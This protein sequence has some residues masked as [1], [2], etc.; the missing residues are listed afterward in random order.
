M[1]GPN[2][3]FVNALGNTLDVDN[4]QLITTSGSPGQTPWTAGAYSATGYPAVSV[5]TLNSGVGTGHMMIG[6]N[7]AAGVPLINDFVTKPPFIGT[8]S[9]YSLYFD[10]DGSL[11]LALINGIEVARQ[12]ML[13]PSTGDS[14]QIN[15]DGISVTFKV[16]G[17]LLY[18]FPL[19]VTSFYLPLHVTWTS[20]YS[21]AISVLTIFPISVSLAIPSNV[22][23]Y[24]N[25]IT[26][27]H[28]QKPN[29]MSVVGVIAGAGADIV[30][31]TQTIQPAFNLETAV[32][33]QL[34]ILGLWI[35]QS[36]R[37]ANVLI[38]GF[39][40]FSEVSTGLPDG[41]QET[42]G[43]LTNSSK[44]GVWFNL[45]Q[46]DSGTTILNDV[47][48]LTILKAK[49]VKNQWNGTISG[50]E[51]ALQYIV[52]AACSIADT[53]NLTLTI[54]VPV[55]ITPLEEA[56]LESLDLIPRPAGVRID[57]ITFAP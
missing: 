13:G 41:L 15:Y 55:P 38:I 17:L 6:L 12:P 28:N 39:F 53:G 27:E 33:T 32:G 14:G 21:G 40:G 1:S 45:G 56:L 51:Q 34:D 57:S 37:I 9:T 22:S 42:F 26:S 43:E 49:I 3:V 23:A 20:F 31:A 54:N 2:F 11:C 19:S 18:Y 52:G 36:R 44:G 25:L 47:A 24:T 46:V 5:T 30:A 29:F 4:T 7:I 48:Y 35:G 8:S 50:I 10:G 16:N